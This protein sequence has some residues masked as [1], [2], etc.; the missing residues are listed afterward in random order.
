L[1]LHEIVK[2]LGTRTA[3]PVCSGNQHFT[4]G[5]IGRRPRAHV[6]QSWENAI[7]IAVVNMTAEPHRVGY[8]FGP[9]RATDSSGFFNLTARP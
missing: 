5:M 6:N 7:S 3:E 9:S 8:D 4:S 1:W 2:I